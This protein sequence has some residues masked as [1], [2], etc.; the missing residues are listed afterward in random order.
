MY[1]K[2]RAGLNFRVIDKRLLFT[3]SLPY[4]HGAGFLRGS[5]NRLVRFISY[6]VISIS[7]IRL[8]LG[9]IIVLILL[10]DTVL[11]IRTTTADP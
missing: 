5:P 7:V 6:I 2:V 1:I 8:V 3:R 4:A 9:I 11:T 10:F